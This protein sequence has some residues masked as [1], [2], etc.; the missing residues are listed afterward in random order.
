MTSNRTPT[1]IIRKTYRFESL[2]ADVSQELERLLADLG[3]SDG[4][5]RAR[6][7][8]GTLPPEHE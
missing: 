5:L 2:Y 1:T 4:W 6:D 8:L 3:L 7:M